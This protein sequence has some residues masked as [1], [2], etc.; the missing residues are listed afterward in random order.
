VTF[1]AF[2][3][4]LGT[5]ILNLFKVMAALGAAIFIQWQGFSTLRQTIY[6]SIVSAKRQKGCTLRR[7]AAHRPSHSGA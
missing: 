5:K 2:I 3:F 4:R 6:I 1:G 7:F